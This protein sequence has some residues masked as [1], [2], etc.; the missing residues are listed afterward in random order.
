M[1]STYVF[2]SQCVS[3]KFISLFFSSTN[4]FTSY[5]SFLLISFR[6]TRSYW[7]G[8]SQLALSSSE[9]CYSSSSMSSCAPSL[10]S[11]L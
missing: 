2:S 6:C 7:H 8:K 9:P 11:Q 10:I 1:S 4:S 5:A 3:G